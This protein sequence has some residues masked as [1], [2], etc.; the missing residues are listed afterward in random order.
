MTPK[1]IIAKA[2]EYCPTEQGVDDKCA[3]IILQHLEAAGFKVVKSEDGRLP[4]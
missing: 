1:E 2:L 3:E 4:D